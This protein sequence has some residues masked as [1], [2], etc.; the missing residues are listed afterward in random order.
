M[1]VLPRWQGGGLGRYLLE[2]AYP[3]LGARGCTLLWCNA[4]S[5]ALGFYRH[6]GFTA[7]GEEFET[8]YAGPHYLMYRWLEAAKIH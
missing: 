7:V 2:A 6:A 4:R 1:A 3:L 5:S 8:Q